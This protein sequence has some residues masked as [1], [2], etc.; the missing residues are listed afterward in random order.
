MTKL[1]ELYTEQKE[2]K[3]RKATSTAGAMQRHQQL[4]NVQREI[5]YYEQGD[6]ISKAYIQEKVD[7][8]STIQKEIDLLTGTL[9]EKKRILNEVV[10]GGHISL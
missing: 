10:F 6:S 5:D 1:Q 4:A 9:T 7:E 8:I 2:L 3:E